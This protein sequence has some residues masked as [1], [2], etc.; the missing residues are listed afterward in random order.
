MGKRCCVLVAVLL[1]VLVAAFSLPGAGVR[2]ELSATLPEPLRFVR[3]AT[4]DGLQVKSLEVAAGGGPV[5]VSGAAVIGAPG[6]VPGGDEVAVLWRGIEVG[7]SEAAPDGSFSVSVPPLPDARVSILYG[8]TLPELGACVNVAAMVPGHAVGSA[9]ASSSY[10]STP[11][12]AFNQNWGDMWNAGTGAIAWVLRDLGRELDISGVRLWF[13]GSRIQSR[14]ARVSMSSDGV[15]FAPVAEGSV[16][17]PDSK[18][19]ESPTMAFSFPVGTRARYVKV[20]ADSSYDWTALLEVAVLGRVPLAEVLSAPQ[21]TL[22][23][24][25]GLSGRPWVMGRYGQSGLPWGTVS[26]W[27]DADACWMGVP[28]TTARFRV[29]FS[30]SG[31]GDAYL[32]VVGDDSFV[33]WLD[34]VPVLSGSGSA[35]SATPLVLL[36]GEHALA[37]ECSNSAGPGGLLVSLRGAGGQVLLRSGEGAWECEGNPEAWQLPGAAGDF[38]GAPVVVPRNAA[39]TA[40]PDRDASWVWCQPLDASGSHP[41]GTVRFRRLFEL[42]AAATVTVSVAADNSARVWVDGVPVLDWQSYSSVGSVSFWLPAGE[43]VLAVE[44]VNFSGTAPNPAGLLVSVKDGSG[45]VLLR[46]GDAGWQT[47]GYIP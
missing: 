38:A 15:S 8:P 45:A 29:R 43:H 1:A 36:A 20:E 17:A 27:P 16:T 42:A 30:V 41:A 40:G 31:S 21:W 23:G 10:G 2:A 32:Y 34:G 5:T 37:F 9:S 4:L 12:Q 24:G 19:P 11:S 46:T 18:V 35:L 22:P 7:R 26:G 47:S 33:A 6:A 44:A 14:W 39:W 3:T 28:G 13:A 25:P